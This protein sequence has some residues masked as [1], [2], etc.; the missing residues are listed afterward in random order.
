MKTI[1]AGRSRISP[2][3]QGRS[4]AALGLGLFAALACPSPASAQSGTSDYANQPL[5]TP[6]T[7]GPQAPLR[8]LL[9]V[10]D[11]PGGCWPLLGAG[12]DKV[13]REWRPAGSTLAQSTVIRPPRWRGSRGRIHAL[14]LSAPSPT[15]GTR[16]LA[17]GGSGIEGKGGTI[18]LYRYPGQGPDTGDLLGFLFEGMASQSKR[19]GHAGTVAALAFH[20]TLPILASAGTDG[21][22]LIWNLEDFKPQVQLD[23]DADLPEAERPVPISQI[24]HHGAPVE[25]LT[26]NSRGDR[27]LTGVGLATRP[28]PNGQK[29]ADLPACGL[30]RL[31]D[32]TDF[33]NPRLAGTA[34]AAFPADTPESR[35]PLALSV[36]PNSLALS[37]DDRSVLVGREGGFVD[38]YAIDGDQLRPLSTLSRNHIAV[39]AIACG[40]KGTPAER[41]F[42]VSF[43]G[44]ES[45]H[46]PTPSELAATRNPSSVVEVRSLD[47]PNRLLLRLEVSNLCYALAFG[48]DG[49]QLAYSGGDR[50]AVYLKDLTDLPPDPARPQ[51]PDLRAAGAGSSIWEVGFEKDGEA[52]VVAY[53]RDRDPANRPAPNYSAFDL[54]HRARVAPIPAQ[55][56]QRR[57]TDHLGWRLDPKPADPY[58]RVLIGPD[59]AQY[60]IRL[61]PAR[62]RRIWD[63]TFLPSP[64]GEARPLALAIACESG[65]AIFRLADLRPGTA[66]RRIRHFNG[67]EGPVYCLAPSPDGR[68]LASGSADQTVRIWSLDDIDRPAELGATFESRPDGSIRV[69]SIARRG[70]AEEAGLTPNLSFQSA[71]INGALY[72][73]AHEGGPVPDGNLDDFLALQAKVEPGLALVFAADGPAGPSYFHTSRQDAPSLSLFHAVEGTQWVL[74]MPR[75][76]YDT[77]IIGDAKFL[78]WHLNKATIYRP[79]PTD[80]VEMQVHE[81]A[82]RR[83]EVIEQ[84]LATG[85]TTLALDLAEF[86]WDQEEAAAAI[87]LIASTP[88]RPRLELDV[89]VAGGP[90]QPPRI[91]TIP[92]TPIPAT[93]EAWANGDVLPHILPG[94]GQTRLLVRI[95]PA[96]A[97]RVVSLTLFVGS[98]PHAPP[99]PLGPDGQLVFRGFRGYG[100]QTMSIEVATAN[101]TRPFTFPVRFPDLALAQGH[102]DILAVGF[103]NP[104]HAAGPVEKAQADAEELSAFFQRHLI[105][106]GGRNYSP[107]EIGEPVVLSGP[108]ASSVNIRAALLALAEGAEARAQQQPLADD[109]VAVLLETHL[110]NPLRSGMVEPNDGVLLGSDLR[111]PSAPDKPLTTYEVTEALA[112]IASTGATVLLFLDVVHP[113]RPST[114]L[115]S[116]ATNWVRDLQGRGVVVILAAGDQPSRISGEHRAMARGLVDRDSRLLLGEAPITFDAFRERLIADVKGF[117]AQGQTP[118]FYVPGQNSHLYIRTLLDP[119]PFDPDPFD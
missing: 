111:G 9:F 6:L 16:L 72:G 31:F 82:Y 112:Q 67:H 43:A 24:D 21:F 20:P 98:V 62:D 116:S 35:N 65:I 115:G 70:F 50:Q 64:R 13:V 12:F 59:N 76:I 36:N 87:D 99:A 5:L 34:P 46:R 78:G 108:E 54:T 71:V 58:S 77:S 73:R 100:D 27:L 86:R 52:L 19:R 118:E 93:E 18:A 53:S 106:P 60:P 42:A 83:G 29:L 32:L 109:V 56:L 17:V 41:L 4:I 101:A 102:L 22:V 104:G 1:L 107:G 96:D 11:E 10:G 57:I 37:A 103:E 69:T 90:G 80:F 2:R 28:G 3:L 49:K 8:R 114:G 40:P 68:W 85:S 95:D 91:Q 89:Q 117:T 14:A 94:D 75:G 79:T 25:A 66:L 26:F 55:R 39:E 97:P 61:D 51:A 48:P 44:P 84:L 110:L 105:K 81:K 88:P 23:R 74:W 33:A 30:V 7:G 63:Y 92:I 47:Q 38:F 119:D 15:D 113:H 45:D